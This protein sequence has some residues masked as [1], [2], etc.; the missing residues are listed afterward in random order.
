MPVRVLGPGEPL[1]LLHGFEG[2]LLEFQRLAPRVGRPGPAC[3]IPD[4]LGSDSSP[5]A[6]W[7]YSPAGC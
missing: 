1:L 5:V 6:A 7:P 2:S 3:F 4:L